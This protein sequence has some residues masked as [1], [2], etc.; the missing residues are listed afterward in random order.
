MLTLNSPE[1]NRSLAGELANINAN[2]ETKIR[3]NAAE[4]Q[5]SIN[6]KAPPGMPGFKQGETD[7]ARF[8]VT[9]EQLMKDVALQPSFWRLAVLAAT[10]KDKAAHNFV[11]LEMA[12]VDWPELKVKF[13]ERFKLQ[14]LALHIQLH[15]MRQREESID[16]FFGRFSEVA[17]QLHHPESTPHVIA[18]FIQ[19]L[20]P[21]LRQPTLLGLRAKLAMQPM[22]LSVALISAKEAEAQRSFNDQHRYQSSRQRGNRFSSYRKQKQPSQ[23]NTERN[24]FERKRARVEDNDEKPGA[25]STGRP[26][27]GRPHRRGRGRGRSHAFHT[28]KVRIILNDD[29]EMSKE[30]PT[31]LT[32]ENKVNSTSSDE[33]NKKEIP[34]HP[35]PAEVNNKQIVF[36]YDIGAERSILSKAWCERNNITWQPTSALAQSYHA[37]SPPTPLVGEVIAKLRLQGGEFEHKFFV[38]HLLLMVCLVRIWPQRRQWSLSSP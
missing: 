24:D 7:P 9:F 11:R 29:V 2:G 30:P 17:Q 14:P 31:T 12:N 27:R 38:D 1:V 28:D 10:E 32:K 4:P 34:R 18:T 5:S 20:H 22:E 15:T 16:T 35:V 23:S 3:G 36:K 21:V 25:T 33:G 8:F 13:I 19:A 6:F 37:L 26:F